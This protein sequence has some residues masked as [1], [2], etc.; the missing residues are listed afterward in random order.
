MVTFMLV[1]LIGVTYYQK[2]LNKMKNI[3]M[4]IDCKELFHD[5]KPLG[6][7]SNTTEIYECCT[8]CGREASLRDVVTLY[9]CESGI[10]LLNMRVRFGAW[11]EA[12]QAD[13]PYGPGSGT[14]RIFVPDTDI[15]F[16]EC[17][18]YDIIKTDNVVVDR[19]G[20]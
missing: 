13:D 7:S 11:D 17:G 9:T 8:E 15:E 18:S 16:I 19:E 12:M 2:G 4:C 5:G 6:Q 3:M 14:Y 10:S 1:I 20:A